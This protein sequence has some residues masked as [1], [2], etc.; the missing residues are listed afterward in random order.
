MGV[1][2]GERLGVNRGGERPTGLWDSYSPIAVPNTAGWGVGNQERQYQ[3]TSASQC[4]AAGRVSGLARM[5]VG[6]VEGLER[7]FVECSV[8]GKYRLSHGP[9]IFPL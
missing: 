4:G 6:R 3:S 9:D 5:W 1:V 8:F 7:W 2:G